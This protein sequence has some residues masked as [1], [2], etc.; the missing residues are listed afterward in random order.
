MCER[1]ESIE[2]FEGTM[3]PNMYCLQDSHLL[4]TW[5]TCMSKADAAVS[6]QVYQLLVSI[7]PSL[8]SGMAITLCPLFK[9]HCNG[10]QKS[11]ITSPKWLNSAVHWQRQCQ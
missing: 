6:A 11:A 5:K 9:C 8:S 7:L 1:D 10:V 4:L 3:K 2:G